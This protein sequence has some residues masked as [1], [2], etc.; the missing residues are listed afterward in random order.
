MN[1]IIRRLL[2]G[3]LLTSAVVSVLGGAQSAPAPLGIVPAPPAPQLLTVN[4]WTDKASYVVG[5]TATIQFYVSQPSY[6]YIYDIQP[7][8]VV[9]L[10]F[11]NAYDQANYKAAGVHSLPNANYRFLVS[12]PTG[13]ERLQILASPTNLGLTPSAYSEPF[14]MM[15]PNPEMA[16]EKIQVQ[17]LG[18][19]PQPTVASAWTSFQI[20]PAY[21]YTPPSYTPPPY[22]TPP[23]SP[24][25]PPGYSFCP[26]FYS[27]PGA[28]WYWQDGQWHLGIPGSGWY[29]Y[30]GS[31]GRWSFRIIL[32]FGS[33]G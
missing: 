15:A 3:V 17:I 9:R 27:Y 4:V 18:I 22:Y 1:S 5:E 2:L 14:P 6:I 12:P 33:G 31:D 8:G 16:T 10:I 20:L 26:P 25:P 13:T 28:T 32:R 21:T 29:W 23:P 7:D 11:P 24:S 30:F 19:V